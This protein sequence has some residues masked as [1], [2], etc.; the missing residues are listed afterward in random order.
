MAI[1]KAYG[2]SV[3][4]IHFDALR[5]AALRRDEVN[6]LAYHV[7]RLLAGEGTASSEWQHLGLLIEVE[8]D[9]DGGPEG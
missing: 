2:P 8:P 1:L 7:T 5:V 4:V 6:H 3:A 9:T